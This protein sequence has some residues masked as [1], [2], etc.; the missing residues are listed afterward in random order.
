MK[1]IYSILLLFPATPGFAQI[2]IT[3]GD[4]QEKTI[5]L[6]VNQQ[7]G[8]GITF[9]FSSIK[10]LDG[11]Q[12]TSKIG[13]TEKG[14]G[15]APYKK[16]IVDSGF[17]NAGQRFYNQYYRNCFIV[18]STQLFIVVKKFWADR[19]SKKDIERRNN[20]N[21]IDNDFDLYIQFDYF[22]KR[23][24]E[25]MPI[26]KIDTVFNMGNNITRSDYEIYREDNYSFYEFVLIK[27]MEAVDYKFY[28][29]RF[30]LSRNRKKLDT[31]LNFYRT[32][33]DYPILKDSIRRQGIYMTFT[34]FR[35]NTP[36]IENFTVQKNKKVGK[37]LFTLKNG[38]SVEVIKYW[39]YCD[40]KDIFCY[41]LSH[42]IQRVGNTFEFFA[43]SKILVNN[44]VYVPPSSNVPGA[45]INYSTY[46]KRYQPYQFDLESGD[47]Y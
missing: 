28:A 29:D 3:P 23:G 47:V 20:T 18:D 30:P 32:K 21:N 37:L 14:I 17:Q 15:R 39:G 2:G 42:P 19:S 41:D 22:I 10:L 5:Y 46:E 13:F 33:M 35:N 16:L 25:Y 8:E 9:P 27:M 31:I 40:G 1:S 45:N 44:S 36:S 24:D 4:L 34:E 43:M 38:Q 11:R 12:D 7:T 26:K 6:K